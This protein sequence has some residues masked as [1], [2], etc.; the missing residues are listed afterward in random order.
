M[1]RAM[2]RMW[3][4]GLSI[5][6]S[7]RVTPASIISSTS[8]V[9]PIFSAKVVSDM[10]ESPTMTCMRRKR[11]ESPCGSSRVLM[12]GRAR[13]VAEEMPS[14][15]WSARCESTNPG[16]K[17]PVARP[18]MPAPQMSWRVIMNGSSCLPRLRSGRWRP[19]R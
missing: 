2:S 9:E 11:S 5:S 13:V 6:K 1:S 4:M 12:I 7:G 14:H 18:T 16:W 3:P 19:T 8:S 10:L 17:P 15:T